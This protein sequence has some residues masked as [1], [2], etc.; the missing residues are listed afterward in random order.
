MGGADKG[1]GRDTSKQAPKGRALGICRKVGL[2]LS[3]ELLGGPLSTRTP[4]HLVSGAN[5]QKSG[6]GDF[7]YDPS[8]VVSDFYLES[9]LTFT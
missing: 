2:C 6:F 5:G 1:Y 4:F 3:L 7:C 9:L 8:Y